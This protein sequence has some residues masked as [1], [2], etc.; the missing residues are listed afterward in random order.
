MFI[1]ILSHQSIITKR[2]SALVIIKLAKNTFWP[3]KPRME[4]ALHMGSPYL[5]PIW[6]SDFGK[7]CHVTSATP[8]KE[9]LCCLIA[10]DLRD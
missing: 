1:M 4:L 10:A 6:L 9:A 8:Y 5:P 3:A 7:A 2:E